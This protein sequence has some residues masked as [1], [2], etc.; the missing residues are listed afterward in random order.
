[1][2]GVC[3][4]RTES[5]I[6]ELDPTVG[7]GSLVGSVDSDTRRVLAEF[8]GILSKRYSVFM[9]CCLLLINKTRTKQKNYI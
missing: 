8:F 3:T 1:V 4:E 5:E 9:R 2:V 7:V 6:R